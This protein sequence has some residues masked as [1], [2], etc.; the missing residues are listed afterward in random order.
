MGEKWLDDTHP[1]MAIEGLTDGA[2]INIHRKYINI[3]F[4][5]VIFPNGAICTFN[6]GRGLAD[7][8][9]ECYM[10]RLQEAGVRA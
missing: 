9:R 7:Y 4:E 3:T 10:L 2:Y 1:G 5:N 6:D 8:F